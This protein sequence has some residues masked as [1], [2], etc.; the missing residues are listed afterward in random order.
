MIDG[1]TKEAARAAARSD[2]LDPDEQIACELV[3]SSI[4]AELGGLDPIIHGP[5][6]VIRGYRRPR[7][8]CYLED[9]RYRARPFLGGH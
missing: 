7:W 9:P 1:K 2:G 3:Q 6:G 8:H 4:S 5:T